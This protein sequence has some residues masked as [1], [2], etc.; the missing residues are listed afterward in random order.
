LKG[1]R[2]KLISAK[3][4]S[5]NN[6]L[7][8]GIERKREINGRYYDMSGKRRTSK[9]NTVVGLGCAPVKQSVEQEGNLQASRKRGGESRGERG[10]KRKGRMDG[11]M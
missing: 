10:K 7:T 8:R 5:L 6:S 9:K 3:F 2:E 4:G 1:A 11:R